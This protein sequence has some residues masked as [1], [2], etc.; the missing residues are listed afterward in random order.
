MQIFYY[1]FI[2]T[3]NRSFFRFNIKL[4]NLSSVF[5]ELN[6]V[7][8][9]NLSIMFHLL[10]LNLFKE[11]SAHYEKYHKMQPL[12]AKIYALLVFNNCTEG[13][14]FDDFVELLQASKS[15]VSHSLNVLIEMNFIEQHKKENERKRYFRINQNLFL[16]RL[17][18][19]QERL[20]EEKKVYSKI[21][22]FKKSKIPVLF[23]DEAFALYIS[24]LEDAT[25]SITKTIQN[26]KLHI[27][28][29]EKST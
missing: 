25:D 4:T 8:H 27:K 5:A 7:L 14:T 17:E 18:D 6:V 10:N 9:K 24:H 2:L 26:L 11:V 23:K 22:E 16:K 13:L 12:T 1:F 20:R 29:N 3:E 19:V 15:S 21:R 28:T